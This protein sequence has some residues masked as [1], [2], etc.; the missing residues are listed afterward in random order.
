MIG[1]VG[2]LCAQIIARLPSLRR[3]YFVAESICIFRPR[4]IV[5]VVGKLR[6]TKLRHEWSSK[7]AALPGGLTSSVRRDP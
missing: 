3:K 4:G 6:T 2:V 7:D 5:R 1:M